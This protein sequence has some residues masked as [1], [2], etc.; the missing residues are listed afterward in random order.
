MRGLNVLYDRDGDGEF[1]HFYS[2]PFAGGQFF[3]VVERRG[4]YDGYGA[5]KAPFRIAAQK[6][7]MRPKA[8]PQA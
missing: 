8:M 3:E 6:R 5:A 2:L 7:L 1:F 4:G